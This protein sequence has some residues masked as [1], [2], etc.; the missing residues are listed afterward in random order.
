MA[1]HR[2]DSDDHLIERNS[3]KAT[4]KDQSM[5]EQLR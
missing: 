2:I 1:N 3:S 5:M 4:M